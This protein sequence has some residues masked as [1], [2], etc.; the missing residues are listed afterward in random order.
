MY[1][2]QLPLV[3]VQVLIDKYQSRSLGYKRKKER[4]KR[5]RFTTPEKII[6]SA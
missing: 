6:L 4:K 2:H 5:S 1:N 3:E